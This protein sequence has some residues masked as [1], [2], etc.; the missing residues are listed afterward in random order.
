MFFYFLI[1]RSTCFVAYF[2]ILIS[3]KLRGNVVGIP[4]LTL[5]TR[6]NSK[7]L[8]LSSKNKTHVYSLLVTFDVLRV[9][10]I[11]EKSEFLCAV[12]RILIYSDPKILQMS[13][14]LSFSD[15]TWPAVVIKLLPSYKKFRRDFFKKLSLIPK[16]IFN[17]EYLYQYTC[18]F[19]LI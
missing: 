18:C 17:G 9:Y 2:H 14:L 15:K 3:Q 7:E 11:T 6:E 13:F 8:K 12:F 19:I 16:R 4:L 1:C 5:R 10:V